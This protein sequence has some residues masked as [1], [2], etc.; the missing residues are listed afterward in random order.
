MPVIKKTV[1][2]LIMANIVLISKNKEYESFLASFN[3]KVFEAF[4]SDMFD[5]EPDIIILDYEIE[6]SK[7]ILME[8]SNKNSAKEYEIFCLAEN[9]NFEECSKYGVKTILKPVN[10]E[11]LINEINLSYKNKEKFSVLQKENLELKK[12]LYQ[13]DT[14]YN[15]SS[16]F[17]GTLDK[18][19]L[20]EVMFETFER[21]L[22]FDVACALFKENL[23]DE[24]LKF[25]INSLKKTTDETNSNL[26][27]R[28]AISAKQEGLNEI[29]PSKYEV[30]IIQNVKPSYKNEF[31]DSTLSNF[32]TLIAPIIIKDKFE[33]IIEVFRKNPFTK[34]DGACFQSI[35]HQI[36][37]PLRSAVLYEEIKN[38]NLELTRLEK[39]KSEFVSIVS[40]EL[41][42]PLTPINNALN[43]ILSE[44]GGKIGD[45]NKNFAQMAKRNVSRL[46][47]II[48][49]LLDLSRMQTGKFDFQFKKTPIYN[50]LE[51][52]YNTFKNQAS[53]KKIEF[54]FNADKN[55]PDVYIDSHRI[56]QI[57]SNIITNALKFTNEN[58]QISLGAELLT[59]V[60][61]DKLISPYA[62]EYKG[63]FIRI[64]VKDTGVGIEKEDIP[65][66]FDK[67]SQI[68][69]SLSR[70]TG[71]IGL[72]L[73]ITKH[74]IDA[75]LG[76]IWVDS[77][78][79]EGSTF[80]IVLPVYSESKAFETELN[81]KIKNAS[82]TA[83]F[84]IKENGQTPEFYNRLKDE[85]IIKLTKNSKEFINCADDKCITKVFISGLD[86]KAYDFISLRIDEEINKNNEKHDIVLSKSYYSKV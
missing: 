19:K 39:I 32:D 33:G 73:T 80:N 18:E 74:F 67:F 41:R 17:A 24:K 60:E 44:Q 30:E 38:A 84:I 62:K 58:G 71:G 12:N 53:A 7:M 81:L 49:D 4:S 31:Y 61:K 16:K 45:V 23:E 37:P 34:E 5:F 77:V 10:K 6:N 79:N 20:Y 70:N 63:G 22:S 25:Y 15:A 75:H 13:I 66:I 28:L 42:T 82:E 11:F 14:F 50:S 46:S 48:E 83:Y 78:K 69:N 59:S 65:K 56:D 21:I 55:L 9:E 52:A 1:K 29:K 51:L 68:E 54:S 72:G 76:G 47:G 35:V 26:I 8:L 85:N 40:H 86:R 43:I 2:I 27:K 64:Y 57:L 3:L 36:L